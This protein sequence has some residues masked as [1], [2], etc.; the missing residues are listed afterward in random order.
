MLAHVDCLLIAWGA[1]Q[2]IEKTAA[3][4]GC[5]FADLRW[6]EHP[7]PPLINDPASVD[8]VERVAKQLVGDEGWERLPAPSMAAED[9]S[10]L[11]RESYFHAIDFTLQLYHHG[12]WN[13]T[14]QQPEGEGAL[15]VQGRMEAHS[16]F[17]ASGTRPWARCMGCTPADLPWTSP[18][19]TWVQLSM[20]T[21]RWRMLEGRRGSTWNCRDR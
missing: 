15:G 13:Q 21:L 5:S 8:V 18:C 2:V 7:Y 12:Y 9:F 3:A 20:L 1:H 19:F 17:W 6:R 4:H 16:P 10:F 11:A 14:W